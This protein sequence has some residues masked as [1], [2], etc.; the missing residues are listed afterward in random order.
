MA[1]PIR[2]LGTDSVTALKIADCWIPAARPP[3]ICHRN[4]GATSG[5]AAVASC[6]TA[7]R[8]SDAPSSVRTPNLS[9]STP[10]GR[11][12]K[13]ATTVATENSAPTSNRLAPRSCAYRGTVRPRAP[14]VPNTAA[15]AT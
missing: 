10:A 13:A 12:R 2:P 6:E 3:R 4:R 14:M 8:I 5:V 15:A 11:A 7:V 1:R 9:T